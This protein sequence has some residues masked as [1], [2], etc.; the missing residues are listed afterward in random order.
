MRK[1][2]FGAIVIIFVVFAC[3]LVLNE[4]NGSTTSEVDTQQFYAEIE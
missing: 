1:N 3:F 4:M 2:I